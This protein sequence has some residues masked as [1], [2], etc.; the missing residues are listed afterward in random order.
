MSRSDQN[1]F[2]PLQTYSARSPCIIN[3]G[4]KSRKE[5]CDHSVYILYSRIS[6]DLQELYVV[7]FHACGKLIACTEIGPKGVK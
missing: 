6:E 5:M 1:L 7:K 4:L 3:Y 2:L